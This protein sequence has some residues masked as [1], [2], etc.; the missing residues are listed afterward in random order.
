MS[1]STLSGGVS[2]QSPVVTCEDLGLSVTSGASATSGTSGD[3]LRHPGLAAGHK[4]SAA[5][6]GGADT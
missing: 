6:V 2:E 1:G 4:Y 3:G 5:T